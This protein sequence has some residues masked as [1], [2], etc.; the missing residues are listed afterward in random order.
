MR[1]GMNVTSI[2]KAVTGHVQLIDTA[3]T[4]I[5]QRCVPPSASMHNSRKRSVRLVVVKNA[6]SK[7]RAIRSTL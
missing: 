2:R 5:H 4:E 6:H 1:D 7:E 3:R